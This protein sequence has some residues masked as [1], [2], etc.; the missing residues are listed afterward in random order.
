MENGPKNYKISK[1][2]FLM[3]FLLIRDHFIIVIITKSK[4][5]IYVNIYQYHYIGF[6]GSPSPIINHILVEKERFLCVDFQNSLIKI[7][8]YWPDICTFLDCLFGHPYWHSFWI[9]K[10]IIW[11]YYRSDKAVFWLNKVPFSWIRVDKVKSQFSPKPL[12]LLT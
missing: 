5:H 1:M 10:Q 2:P 11:D 8:I 12:E 3:I 7:S 4:R 9:L 6:T